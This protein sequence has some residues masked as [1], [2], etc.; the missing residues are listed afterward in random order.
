M[1]TDDW[2][3]TWYNVQVT[4]DDSRAGCPKRVPAWLLEPL[5]DR[6]EPLHHQ[7]LER[8]S[9]RGGLSP[10]ELWCHAHAAHRPPEDHSRAFWALLDDYK[11][12]RDRGADT[13]VRTWFRDW[14]L[15]DRPG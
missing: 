6:I 12:G 3:R 5:R 2:L 1:T 9:D 13:V 8:L 15:T 11:R 14:C 4:S 7:T 10:T